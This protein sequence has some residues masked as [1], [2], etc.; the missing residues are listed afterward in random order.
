[1]KSGFTGSAVLRELPRGEMIRRSLPLKWHGEFVQPLFCRSAI[2]GCTITIPK[3]FLTDG[4][5]VP[6]FFWRMISDTD[7]DILYPSFLHDLLYALNG[8]LPSALTNGNPVN[9]TREQCDEILFEQMEAVGCGWF[10]RH[11]AYRALRMF[12][13]AAWDDDLR[14]RKLAGIIE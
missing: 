6:R 1:M 3:G 2:A 11:S 13:Q 10:K 7:P 5:S 9:L 12:G 14:L 4:A 8:R